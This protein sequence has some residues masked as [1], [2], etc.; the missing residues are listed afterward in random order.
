MSLPTA[1]FALPHVGTTGNQG[2]D[3]AA[4][5][6]PQVR[7]L[8]WCR[9]LAQWSVRSHDCA[10]F[11]AT[12][13]QSFLKRLLRQHTPG[14]RMMLVLD[15]A[16]YHHAILLAPFLRNHARNLRLL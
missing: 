2:S 7:R 3:L 1:R 15:N 6:D 14:R 16:R 5:A 9:Q 11:N 10:I 4:R 12:T 13:F 8:L